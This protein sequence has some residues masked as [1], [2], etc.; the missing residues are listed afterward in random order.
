M[1]VPLARTPDGPAPV[2]LVG[3]E[4]TVLDCL[5]RPLPP[6]F[7]VLTAVGGARALE[8]LGS[9]PVAAVVSELG[10]PEMDGA[11]LLSRVHALHPDVVRV[12][13][14]GRSDART[15][16]AAV[17]EARVHRFLTRPCPVPVLAAELDGALAQHRALVAEREARASL[18][19]RVVEALAETL[20]VAQPAASGRALR[21]ARTVAELAAVLQVETWE[22][23]A[24]AL[25]S[26][27]G[28]VGVPASVLA[29]LDAGRP[30]TEDESAAVGR[31]PAISRDLVGRIPGLD[32]I[33]L[34]IGWHLARYDG[35]GSA[36][37]VPRGEDLPLPA[38]VLR[39]A[40]DF[41]AGMAQRPSVQ[42]TIDALRT[43]PGAYDPRVL[44]ALVA[45][46]DVP[47]SGV[48]SPEVD[49]ADL[50]PGMV[51]DDDVRTTDGVLLVSRGTRV[52]DTLVRRI[53]DFAERDRV[54][55]RIRV[56]P[57]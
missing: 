54:G 53:A 40:V 6:R 41:D 46:H 35:G 57:G 10:M 18:L 45:C 2:L 26:Q 33:G 44:A 31:V 3:D 21:V 9:E 55:R 14:T 28:A 43:D 38:R 42:A 16:V 23:E 49:V 51:V 56:Q 48:P 27:L 25:L 30:L 17:N 34:A 11:T 8:V 5:R 13:L 37:G 39:L 12:V 7:R 1:N 4:A 47:G 52:T 20:S 19:G 29:K 36:P 15:A 50:A 24:T 32:G 22:L